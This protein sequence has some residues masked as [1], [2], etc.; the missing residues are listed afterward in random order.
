MKRKL[1]LIPLPSEVVGLITLGDPLS[2]NLEELLQGSRDALA[3]VES[4]MRRCQDVW[5]SV[6]Q[7]TPNVPFSSVLHLWV[8]PQSRFLRGKLDKSDRQWRTGCLK[9]YAEMLNILSITSLMMRQCITSEIP[10]NCARHG[11]ESIREQLQARTPGVKKHLFRSRAL[12]SFLMREKSRK[13]S[14]LSDPGPDVLNSLAER[15]EI[16]CSSVAFEGF[17]LDYLLDSE[18][19]M[20][21]RSLSPRFPASEQTEA[22]SPSQDSGVLQMMQRSASRFRLSAGMCK[23]PDSAPLVSLYHSLVDHFSADTSAKQNILKWAFVSVVSDRLYC[24]DSILDIPNHAILRPLRIIGELTV[25][26]IQVP[27]G[28]FK[29]QETIKSLPES[30]AAVREIAKVLEG[31]QFRRSPLEIAEDLSQVETMIRDMGT[32]SRQG[33]ELTFDTFFV[34]FIVVV[35]AAPPQNAVGIGQLLDVFGFL[36]YPFPSCHAVTT[37]S[38]WLSYVETFLGQDHPPELASKISGLLNAS[39]LCESQR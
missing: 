23:C 17:V 10:V 27:A 36:D 12:R 28:Y 35:S 5:N 33:M 2:S 11:W 38:A 16:C 31:L 30:H 25:S 14:S 3:H 7:A 8:T 22:V 19:N 18:L 39:S 4:R 1:E 15:S 13:S 34:L 32:D 9:V 24:I 20:V 21:A 26:D 29:D 37:F 6:S